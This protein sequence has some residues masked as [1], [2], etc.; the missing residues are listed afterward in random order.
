MEWTESITESGS[1]TARRKPSQ[2]NVKRNTRVGLFLTK[3]GAA[4]PG[5]TILHEIVFHT[6]TPGLLHSPL[7]SL[8]DGFVIFG[9]ENCTHEHFEET[10][11]QQG[12]PGQDNE[13]YNL[14]VILPL[15]Q[16]CCRRYRNQIHLVHGNSFQLHNIGKF[17]QS[18]ERDI[19]HRRAS[20]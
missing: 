10:C 5:R 19:A 6:R 20:Q 13:S 8:K 1:R 12:Y 7:T 15:Y 17:F 11:N 18:S 14:L 2:I 4:E 3:D 16:N 9:N